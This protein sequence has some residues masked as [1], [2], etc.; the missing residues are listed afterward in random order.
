M[1]EG[2]LP[3]ARL[4]KAHT[5][6]SAASRRRKG[7]TCRIP[8]LLVESP[9]ERGGSLAIRR[10]TGVICFPPAR[11]RSRRVELLVAIAIALFFT[12]GCASSS[13][14]RRSDDAGAPLSDG[15]ADADD[16]GGGAKDGGAANDS[17]TGGGDGGWR[18]GENT[19]VCECYDVA[20]LPAGYNLPACGV[21]PCCIS[22]DV[23]ADAGLAPGCDCYSTSYLAGMQL[24]CAGQQATIDGE[25]YSSATV[26]ATCPP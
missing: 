23:H 24:T 11:L 8:M 25:G 18:C 26:V 20:G 3:A 19:D 2:D 21:F 1:E 15:A 7:L 10:T 16:A 4:G 9:R 14:G 12:P 22:Y 17:S 6:Q 5:R 13:S